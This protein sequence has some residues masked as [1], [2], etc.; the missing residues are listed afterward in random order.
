MVRVACCNF[1]GLFFLGQG[2]EVKR[3]V[4]VSQYL[5][6][7]L[8]TDSLSKEGPTKH[9]CSARRSRSLNILSATLQYRLATIE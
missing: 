1:V 7:Y 9:S 2:A 4:A 5:V 8:L 3:E 6:Q